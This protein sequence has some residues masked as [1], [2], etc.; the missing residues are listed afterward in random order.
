MRA[1]P[2]I[3]TL[4]EGPLHAALKEYYLDLDDELEVPIDGYVA[5]IMR[6]GFII[7][8]QTGGFSP[9]ARKLRDLTQRH[10]VRLVHPVASE[11]WLVKTDPRTGETTR[12]RSPKRGG[13]EQIFE[14]LVAIPDLMAE[15]NFELEVMLV[16]LE[17]LR[18]F[19]RKRRRPGWIVEEKRLVS[20]GA[21]TILRSPQDLLALL[22]DDL[23]DPFDTKLLA[24]HWGKPRWLA[25][26]AAYSLKKCGAIVAGERTRDGIR[27]HVS[28]GFC[29]PR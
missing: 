17:E 29:S 2:H 1:V 16:E 27:Y 5:D 10:R 9:I 13:V 20:V 18:R 23:P 24:A 6:D 12:R 15:P 25:Q 26:K 21:R 14:P 7:E 28:V 11:R 4:G 3:G 22:P 19:G 8:I